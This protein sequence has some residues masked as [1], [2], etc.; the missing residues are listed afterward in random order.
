VKA[1]LNQSK[2]VCGA[3]PKDGEYGNPIVV[4]KATKYNKAVTAPNP[5]YYPNTKQ[6]QIE[7]DNQGTRIDEK[8]VPQSNN[9]KCSGNNCATTNNSTTTN[10][11]TNN[12]A[13][14]K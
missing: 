11:N 7:S 3:T 6:D 1:A 12:D 5:N 14:K 4:I 8:L 9:N 10:N 13:G 2:T